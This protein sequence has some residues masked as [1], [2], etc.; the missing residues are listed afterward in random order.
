MKAKHFAVIAGV[1]LAIFSAVVIVV[2]HRNNDPVPLKIDHGDFFHRFQPVPTTAQKNVSV[3]NIGSI[4]DLK[5][6]EITV[7]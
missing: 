1:L 4:A 6:V 3:A 5:P 7:R 2:G